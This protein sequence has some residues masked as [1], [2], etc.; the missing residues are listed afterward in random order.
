MMQSVFFLV[1]LAMIG[2]ASAFSMKRSP[3]VRAAK[4]LAMAPLVDA[5]LAEIATSCKYNYYFQNCNIHNFYSYA[6]GTIFS[7]FTNGGE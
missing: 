5:P 2:S 4:P 7:Q 1:V 6:L 3:M